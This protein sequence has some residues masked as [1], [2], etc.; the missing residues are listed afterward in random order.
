MC[1]VNTKT[2]LIS[3]FIFALLINH[4]QLTT[5]LLLVPFLFA[6]LMYANN[7]HYFR[8]SYRLKWF[9]LVMFGIFALNTP[10]EHIIVSS[11]VF[12]PTYEGLL[13]GLEQVLRIATLL[14]L[15]SLMLMQNTK[16]QFI[17]GIY[18]LIQP[19]A[20]CGLDLQR[21]AARLWLTLHYVELQQPNTNQL[22]LRGDI[23][24]YLTREVTEM[25]DID[26]VIELENPPQAT[27]DY[28]VLIVMSLLFVITVY[29]GL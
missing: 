14:A 24:Q 13:M 27:E 1:K 5:I 16:Q 20:Y 9:Y 21:F 19:L 11:I 17:S 8:L 22:T 15:L 4:W 12:K 3:F 29:L 25:Q 26:S 6:L 18:F 28:L 7:R 2:Q 10:G 23:F